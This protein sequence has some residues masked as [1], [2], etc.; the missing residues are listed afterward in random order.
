MTGLKFSDKSNKIIAK[1]DDSP[2]H[3]WKMQRIAKGETII[4]IR[5]KM[6]KRYKT[7]VS[8]GFVTIKRN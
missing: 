2:E 4:G 1:W 3:Q 5:G 7:I 6:H 8:I